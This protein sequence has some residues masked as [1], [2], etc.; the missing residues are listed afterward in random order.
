MTDLTAMLTIPS[1]FS[2]WFLL[3]AA[4]AVVAAVS[5]SVMA[6]G[7]W[8]VLVG[9]VASVAGVAS[10]VPQSWRHWRTRDVSDSPLAA[11]AMQVVSAVW[12]VV[13][14]SAVGAWPAAV[15]SAGWVLCLLVSLKVIAPTESPIQ[16][17]RQGLVVLAGTAAAV[18]LMATSP[19]LVGV[20]ANLV[21]LYRWLPVCRGLWAD[22]RTDL[23]GIS[24][25]AW[26]LGVAQAVLWIVYGVLAELPLVV[27]GS[28]PPL[29]VS[30]WVLGLLTRRRT[31]LSASPFVVSDAA[32]FAAWEAEL[33]ELE[34]DA[35]ATPAV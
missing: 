24:P 6:A 31:S 1:T 19:A 26:W 27:A 11:Y 5:S 35:L 30:V 29:L 18:L 16:R 13:Y 10:C 22:R 14:E 25:S 20:G 32:E 15:S 23:A 17:R 3:S 12:W 28:V 8:M 34:L 21:A 4:R 2:F 9:W 7:G 33:A